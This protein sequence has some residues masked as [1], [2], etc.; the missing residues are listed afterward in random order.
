MIKSNVW[1]P[2]PVTDSDVKVS[3]LTVNEFYKLIYKAVQEA[4]EKT[5]V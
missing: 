1:N 5:P 2:P 3:E 4:I